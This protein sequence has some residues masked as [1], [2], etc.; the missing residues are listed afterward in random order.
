M[1]RR[2]VWVSLRRCPINELHQHA[3][4]SVADA[5]AHGYV[6]REGPDAHD[7][8]VGAGG[9]TC[10]NAQD[11]FGGM[12]AIGVGGDDAGG[13]GV[14]REGVVEAGFEGSSL[15]QVDGVTEEVDARMSG[16]S[17][18]DGGEFRAAAVID[19]DEGV[20]AAAEEFGYKGR[21]S[22]S[23]LVGGDEDGGHASSGCSTKGHGQAPPDPIGGMPGRE[24]YARKAWSRSARMSSGASMPTERR[25][26]L[27]WIPMRW[28]CLGERSRCE[29]IDR[30]EHHGVD[31]AERGGADDHFKG[32]HEAEDLFPARVANFE[33]DHGAVEALREE[34]GDGG[35]V[36]MPGIGREVD[37]G[38]TRVL[39]QPGSDPARV[40]A[41]AL[42]AQ[43]EGLDAAHGEVAFEGPEDGSEI[44]AEGAQGI[45]V[46]CIADHDARPARRRG[47]RDTW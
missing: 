26:R 11:I 15:A 23:R 39:G 18:E 2:P 40:G 9:E 29:L 5:A 43:R 10:G 28:R 17:L 37:A 19:D 20:G 31:V 44:A 1:P 38:H 16:D 24:A 13:A 41:L 34:P 8:S 21:E 14:L 45:C 12:L 6:A 4:E 30:I 3:G 27:S 33:A 46:G 36:G 22:F 47:R 25:T 32:V 42:H 35:G 7:E